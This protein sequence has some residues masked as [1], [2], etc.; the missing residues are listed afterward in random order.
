MSVSM[1]HYLGF[2]ISLGEPDFDKVDLVEKEHPEYSAYEFVR[3]KTDIKSNVRL[4]VDGMCG[5]YSYLIYVIKELTDEELYCAEAS[6]ELP[7]YHFLE[8]SE[9]IKDLVKA[10][11]DIN[12][13]EIIPFENI[14]L[15]SLFHSH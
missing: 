6:Y 15:I 5:N 7:L 13:D 11:C 9:I 14:R 4:I 1:T 10:Y 12:N 8:D 2:G 3:D